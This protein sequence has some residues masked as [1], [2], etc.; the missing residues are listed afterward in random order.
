[1]RTVQAVNQPSCSFIVQTAPCLPWI[2]TH[3]IRQTQGKAE[4]TPVAEH[5]G[6]DDSYEWNLRTNN[7]YQ[8]KD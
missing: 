6:K 1:M 4:G 2:S 5:L 8:S 3:N 7:D